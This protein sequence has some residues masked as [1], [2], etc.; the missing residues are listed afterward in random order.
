M[1][2]VLDLSNNKFGG[3]IPFDFHRLQGF[4]VNASSEYLYY[5]IPSNIRIVI[6]GVDYTLEYVLAID[7]IMDLSNNNLIGEIPA[8][9]GN[10]SSLRLL[11]LSGNHLER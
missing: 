4:R 3:R 10:L 1:L 5:G 6:K 9:I 11:N 7:A 2:Q 8:S